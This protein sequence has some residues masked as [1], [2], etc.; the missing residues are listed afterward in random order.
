MAARRDVLIVRV[1]P[2]AEGLERGV[3]QVVLM[4]DL[5]VCVFS[6]FEATWSDNSFLLMF[7]G[8]RNLVFLLLGGIGHHGALF[9]PNKKFFFIFCF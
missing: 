5:S 7:I 1:E 3:A 6:V 2:H 9:F 4:G 8:D